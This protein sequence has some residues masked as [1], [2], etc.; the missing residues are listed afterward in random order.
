LFTSILQLINNLKS[1]QKYKAKE[2]LCFGKKK[3]FSFVTDFWKP[4][5]LTEYLGPLTKKT[6]PRLGADGSHL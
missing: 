2:N 4:F 1:D 3:T 6:K 5:N